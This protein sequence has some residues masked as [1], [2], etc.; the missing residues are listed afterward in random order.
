MNKI[1]F[2]TVKNGVVITVT[3]DIESCLKISI[4]QTPHENMHLG[5]LKGTYF[6]HRYSPYRTLQSLQH[7]YT[8]L[9]I[10]FRKLLKHS[11]DSQHLLEH[12]KVHL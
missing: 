8:P 10:T 4:I 1:S 5:D 7:Y 11:E 3:S 12:S 6:P 9:D 2:L